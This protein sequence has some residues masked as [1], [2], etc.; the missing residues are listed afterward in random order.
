METASLT[1]KQESLPG[2]FFRRAGALIIDS[3]VLW[4]IEIGFEPLARLICTWLFNEPTDPRLL[5]FFVSMTVAFSFLSYCFY[6][7]YPQVRWGATLGKYAMGLKV[8]M[9]DGEKCP[10]L[11]I[12]LR[13]TIGKAISG[14]PLMAGYFMVLFVDDKRALHDRI[15]GT[16]VVY[17]PS[18]VLNSA[19]GRL[20]CFSGRI[21]RKNFWIAQLALASVWVLLFFIVKNIGADHE[22]LHSLTSADF[23]IKV[24]LYWISLA[25]TVKRLHDRDNSGKL[26]FFIL[27]P[28]FGV[29]YLLLELGFLPGTDGDNMYGRLLNMERSRPV[30]T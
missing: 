17:V 6:Y 19:I 3:V 13:E 14:I 28:I 27:I 15:F 24:V 12:V 9:V 1:S 4:L 20:F 5:I 29:I 25:Y 26:L 7:I 21:G 16:R 18:Q 8:Q 11:K 23:P 2:G 30:I 22:N 10:P